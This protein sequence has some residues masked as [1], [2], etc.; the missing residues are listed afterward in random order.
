MANPNRAMANLPKRP[1]T[2]VLPFEVGRGHGAFTETV[3]EEVAAELCEEGW[4][5]KVTSRAN[6]RW[7]RKGGR[8]CKEYTRRT[9]HVWKRERQD[10]NHV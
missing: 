3:A 8:K 2:E 10:G 9:W 5:T 6:W 4:D 7:D 1:F